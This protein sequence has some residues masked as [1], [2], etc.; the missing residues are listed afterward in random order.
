MAQLPPILVIN[1][2]RAEIRRAKIRERLEAQGLAFEFVE[3]VDGRHIDPA[4]HPLY[5]AE[6]RRRVFGRDLTGGEIGCFLSHRSIL[7]RMVAERIEEVLVLEDDAILGP[8]FLAVLAAIRACPVPYD[9]VRFFGDPRTARRRQRRLFPLGGH[10]WLTRLATAS[11]G[12]QVYLIRLGGARRLLPRMQRIW[13]PVDALMGRSWAHGLRWFT[14]NPP[15]ADYDRSLGSDIGDD[16]FF[17]TFKLGPAR[18]ALH[19]LSRFAFKAVTAMGKRW[20]YWS[21]WPSDRRYLNMPSITAGAGSGL[22]PIKESDRAP[23]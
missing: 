21:A 20:T 13:M 2:A 7:E 3:A 15:V 1:L 5:D 6:R 9:M 22:R 8:D 10:H 19:L 12:A 18:R 11:S 17:V 16:R 14:V 4:A 23:G